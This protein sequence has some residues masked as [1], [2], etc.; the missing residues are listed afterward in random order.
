M[1]FCP[2][3][4]AEFENGIVNCSDCMIE[5]VHSLSQDFQKQKDGLC[6]KTLVRQAIMG[7]KKR[8][9]RV[10]IIY[11]FIAGCFTQFIVYVPVNSL[12]S[13]HDSHLLWQ[14]LYHSNLSLEGDIF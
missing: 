2:R 10:T 1:P 5:L 6:E 12:L 4:G 3:C 13:A 8:N 7:S 9:N 11:L 14:I